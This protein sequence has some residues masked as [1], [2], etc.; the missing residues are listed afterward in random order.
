MREGTFGSPLGRTVGSGHL[1]EQRQVAEPGASGR[2]S[3]SPYCPGCEFG[4]LASASPGQL[5][6]GAFAIASSFPV[7][8]ISATRQV[9]LRAAW[10]SKAAA[11]SRLN[12]S[13]G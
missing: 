7:L 3:A 13:R 6:N 9:G 4:Q 2:R 5:S 1:G 10:S 11:K 12:V 8:T